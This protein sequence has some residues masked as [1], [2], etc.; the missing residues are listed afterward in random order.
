MQCTTLPPG[1]HLFVLSPHFRR[2]ANALADAMEVESLTYAFDV[3][4][5]QYVLDHQLGI[6]EIGYFGDSTTIGNYAGTVMTE[7]HCYGES[8]VHGGHWY[9]DWN[10]SQPLTM[11]TSDWALADTEGVP[12]LETFTRDLL[13]TEHPYRHVVALRPGPSIHAPLYNRFTAKGAT[14]AFHEVA[15]TDDTYWDWCAA[16]VTTPWFAY[17]NVYYAHNVRP[18]ILTM[19]KTGAVVAP[20]IPVDWEYCDATCAS[21]AARA[22]KWAGRPVTRHYEPTTLLFNTEARDAFCAAWR[23]SP[24][25]TAEGLRPTADEYM[26]FAELFGGGK[27]YK[28][29]N[30][31]AQ[32]F[33]PQSTVN[34]SL[35]AAATP[36]FRTQTVVNQS[37]VLILSPADQ[38]PSPM[39][40]PE[41]PLPSPSSFPG[42]PV[43]SP[44]FTSPTPEASNPAL[45]GLT[46]L[47]AIPVGIGAV[48]AVGFL[49]G[50]S[51][52][53]SDPL[54]VMQVYMQSMPNIM[55]MPM[56]TPVG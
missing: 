42:Y 49:G 37:G 55:P 47:V 35:V 14:V 1:F 40:S 36:K 19:Q 48:A 22:A 11:V 8:V 27:L 2:L 34:M 52:P 25:P 3:W 5:A 24:P 32:W 10:A 12:M 31:M 21:T 50:F 46:A 28:P 54:P 16:P 45:Y 18:D 13:S 26:A 20:Y 30:A 4:M 15:R 51:L 44:P 43:F 39:S 9:N 17:S 7:A 41:D 23:A 33:R 6:K 56:S 38:S 29:V 53:S